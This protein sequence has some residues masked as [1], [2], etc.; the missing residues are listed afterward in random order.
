LRYYELDKILK[1]NENYSK[2]PA[3]SSQQTLMLVDKNFKSY[4][5]LLKK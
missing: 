3:A 5:A 2:L 4:F 1:N